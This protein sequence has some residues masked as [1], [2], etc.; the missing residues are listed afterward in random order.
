MKHNKKEE[1]YPSAPALLEVAK[2]EYSKER[3]RTNS[4]DNKAGIFVAAII[5]VTTVFIPIIPFDLIAKEY[6]SGARTDL[7]T[8]SLCILFLAIVLLIIAFFRLYKAISIKSY[9]VPKIEDLKD[10]E[11]LAQDSNVTKKGLIKHYCTII[12]NNQSVNEK[13][14]DSINA[15]L[16]LSLYGFLVL[17]VST[18]A[19]KIILGG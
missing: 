9:M 6:T 19:L 7:L 14:A 16:C 5:A 13:K 4:L 3:E 17:S 10:P 2:D 1:K 12:T 11:M 8:A 15:G 18:I